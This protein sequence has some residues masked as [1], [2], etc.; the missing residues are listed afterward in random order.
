MD[1][2]LE[3]KTVSR[4]D[5]KFTQRRKEI[6]LLFFAPLRELCVLA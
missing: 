1:A 4:K 5:A 2:W 6:F 3:I